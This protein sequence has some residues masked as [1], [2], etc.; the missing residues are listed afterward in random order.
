M[1]LNT[2]TRI[3][4]LLCAL[5]LPTIT[6]CS[7]DAGTPDDELDLDTLEGADE[8]A[9]RDRAPL[10]DEELYV[11]QDG[12]A[13]NQAEEWRASDPEAAEVMEFIADQPISLWVGDWMGDVRA[14]VDD[15]ISRAGDRL[16]VITVYSIPN[17]DCGAWSAGGESDAGAYASFVDQVAAGLDGRQAIIVLEPD[18]LAHTSCLDAAGLAERE[19]MMADAVDVLTEAGGRVYIDAG[20]SNWIPADTMAERLERAGVHAA[21]GI[22]LNVSHTEFTHDEADFADE[23]RDRL[24]DHVHYVIDTSR[25]GRGPSEDNEWCNPLGRAHGELPTLD[26]SREGLDAMLWIKRPGESDGYCNGGPAA[27][28]WWADYALDLA[29]SAG[30]N[31]D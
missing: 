22:A 14:E 7:N 31:G 18:A 21:A 9:R 1:S 5:A 4:P 30:Y 26:T 23:I 15:A 29:L 11:E 17:R 16:Q 19:T 20:D 10:A 6:G 24:G 8:A 27:G 13:E 2:S 28:H 25:N 12:N 3:L